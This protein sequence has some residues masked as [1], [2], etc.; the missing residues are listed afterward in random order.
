MKFNFNIIIIP[1]LVSNNANIS[2]FDLIRGRILYS[3]GET[4][5]LLLL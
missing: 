2:M 1:L 4:E 5:S 3:F